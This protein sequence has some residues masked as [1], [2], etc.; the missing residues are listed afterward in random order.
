MS[1]SP[2]PPSDATQI[3]SAD[4]TSSDLPDYGC[5]TVVI[6]EEPQ[7]RAQPKDKTP[8]PRFT[9]PKPPAW[10]ATWPTSVVTRG[11]PRPPVVRR[12]PKMRAEARKVQLRVQ[13]SKG[14]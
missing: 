5:Y 11:R 8:K 3:I 10:P 2:S 12:Q 13:I 6:H 14:E 1:A 9:P 7:P 4:T